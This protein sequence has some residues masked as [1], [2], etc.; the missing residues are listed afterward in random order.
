MIPIEGEPT[1]FLDV[2]LIS[3]KT[4]NAV[5]R[6]WST[7]RWKSDTSSYV[8]SHI[9]NNGKELLL[10][11]NVNWDLV[12]DSI[13]VVGGYNNRGGVQ[14]GVDAIAVNGAR[15]IGGLAARAG[16]S[17][18]DPPTVYLSG[19]YL[20][21]IANLEDFKTTMTNRAVSYG[22]KTIPE[23]ELL[24]KTLDLLLE[25]PEIRKHSSHLTR[26]YNLLNNGDIQGAYSIVSSLEELES[27]RRPVS[28]KTTT[29]SILTP[30][31]RG[32]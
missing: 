1:R 16:W 3:Q 22:Q 4:S 2:P 19:K 20:A 12:L 32:R 9:I 28:S 23:A 24:M 8:A 14:S 10:G 11:S 30:P 7:D 29:S 5:L 25:H 13:R 6:I 27:S 21:H 26:M 15:F 31:N 17:M 18:H